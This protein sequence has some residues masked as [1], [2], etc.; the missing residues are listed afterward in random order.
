MDAAGLAQ[1]LRAVRSGRQWKC[2]CVAHDDAAPSMI[3]FDGRESVQVRC[4]AGCDQRDLIAEL[5]RRGL[6]DNMRADETPRAAV[7]HETKTHMRNAYLGA[8]TQM[9]D[10]A[11]ALFDG[12]TLCIGT[13]A[14]TY[15]ESREIWTPARSIDDVRYCARCPREKRVQ[16]AIVVAMRSL[17]THAIQ[18][19]QRIYLRDGGFGSVV[20][21]GTMMLGPVGGA[22]MQLVPIVINRE[23]H[24][25]EGL[26]SA[27]S[28]M[29]MN[30]WPTWAMGSCGA[31]E[32]LPVL[33]GVDRLVIWADHDRV[34]PRTGRRP[35]IAA[36]EICRDRW[37]AAGR[38]VTARVPQREGEDPADVWR[39]RCARQ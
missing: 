10:R 34:D 18:A 4:L 38:Q 5:R 20:K 8:E 26:E 1:A 22:A 29:M 6:W 15:L 32:R 31:I 25:A 17:V 30:N 3:I 33:D 2:R 39:A 27:L 14:Q 24:I 7:S 36:A 13:P 23:L 9:R 28:V 16:P 12:S 21:D 37:C 35:G 19:V 11:R